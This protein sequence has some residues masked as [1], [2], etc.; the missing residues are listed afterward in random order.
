MFIW[1]LAIVLLGFFAGLGYLKGAVRTSFSTLGLIVAL[2]LANPLAPMVRPMLPSLGVKHPLW[3]LVLPAAIVFLLIW[4]IAIGLSFLVHRKAYLYY[5]YKTDD[6]TRLRW[7]R[8]NRQLGLCVGLFSGLV[9]FFLFCWII[10]VAGYLTVQVS[11]DENNPPLVKFLNQGRQDLQNVKLDKT[12]ASLDRVNPTFYEI[13][14][15][16]GLLYQNPTL[17]SRINKYPPFLT[18]G[19]RPEFQEI[20]NDKE[21][22]ELLLNR[23]SVSAIINH[24]KFQSL[25]S[26]QPLMDELKQVD[27][28]DLRHY[29]ETGKSAK[30]DEQQI[31]GRWKVD[32]DEVVTSMRKLKPDMTAADMLALRKAAA[33][34][35]G[36]SMTAT[37]DNKV[38]FKVDPALQAAATAALGQP[39]GTPS[40]GARPAIDPRTGRPVPPRAIRPA[41]PKPGAP[42]QSVIVP[43]GEG[44]WKLDGDEYTLTFNDTKGKQHVLKG[45]VEDGQIVF[46][47]DEEELIFLKLE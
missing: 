6:V 44:T 41:P 1:I 46:G 15:I 32:H 17:Q 24:P 7:E 42:P 31:L 5:K 28:A 43:S 47:K 27:L 25:I 11:A 16:L 37:V 9:Y 12:I 39:A 20:A 10:Y 29:L 13:A 35:A 45:R 19:E 26:N 38:T 36:V 34:L 3:L 18:L 21:F 2:F 22:S 4:F 14:D 23:G 33:N 40:P 8:M 30:Y